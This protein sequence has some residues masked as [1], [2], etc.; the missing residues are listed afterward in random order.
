M[1]VVCGRLWGHC[2]TGWREETV[3]LPG[4]SGPDGGVGAVCYQGALHLVL[5]LYSSWSDRR[6]HRMTFSAERMTCY[7]LV[8][9]LAVAAANHTVKCESGWSFRGLPTSLLEGETSGVQRLEQQCW[10]PPLLLLLVSKQQIKIQCCFKLKFDYIHPTK[11]EKPLSASGLIQRWTAILVP[12]VNNVP[13]WAPEA[14]WV[15]PR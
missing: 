5:E 9:S 13:T 2:S 6:L 12:M 1:R 10:N 15:A 11:N 14:L 8:L 7:S 4:L 3:P